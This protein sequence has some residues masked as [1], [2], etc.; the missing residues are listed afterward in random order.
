[1]PLGTPPSVFRSPIAK[2]G[3]DVTEVL[4][5]DDHPIVFDAYRRLLKT[6]GVS[7]IRHCSTV[8]DAFR[9]Y[10]ARKPDVII[11]DL[12]IRTGVLDGVSFIRRLRLL[13]KVTP[14]LVFSMHMDP[15]I[16]SRTLEAGA[17]G[18][19]LKTTASEEIVKAFE[20]VRRGRRYLS[21]DVASELAFIDFRKRGNPLN[22][23]TLRELQTL[24]L[25]T[26][27]KSYAH[28]AE[29]LHVSYK[30]IAN[31]VAQIK[32][33]LGAGSLPELMRIGICHLPSDGGLGA[34]HAS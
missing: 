24:A 29:E 1:M 23:L 22:A 2:A 30:T 19:I 6:A 10:R 5:V 16:I 33:K 18:Y 12:T 21:H 7:N 26:R 3:Q 20:K 27:G 4:I 25:I 31:T 34:V 17:T 28:V 8:V 11:T 9:A 15:V 13:D 32:A 14:I